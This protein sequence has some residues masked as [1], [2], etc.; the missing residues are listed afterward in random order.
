MKV[1]R[2]LTKWRLRD[3]TLFGKVCI[4]KTLAL[5]KLTHIMSC[6]PIPENAIKRLNKLF[7]NFMWGQRDRI[8]RN[9]LIAPIEQ[10]GIGMLDL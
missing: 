6:C 2:E 8:K 10:G 3:L 7:F 5:P 9:T 1:E 4:I